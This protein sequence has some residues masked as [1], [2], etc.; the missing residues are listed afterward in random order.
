MT[1]KTI[2]EELVEGIINDLEMDLS[3]PYYKDLIGFDNKYVV[4]VNLGL[5]YEKTDNGLKL[6]KATP[7]EIGYCFVRLS[8]SKEESR[9]YPVHQVVMS[10]LLEMKIGEWKRFGFNEVNHKKV[11]K[12]YRSLNAWWNLELDTR[13]GNMSKARK[14]STRRKLT[15]D[16]VTQLREEFKTVTKNKMQWYF[17][18]AEELGCSY[19]TVQYNV[20][21]FYNKGI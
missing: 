1:N 6:K 7:N 10:A 5:I 20:L 2:F 3:Q 9:S 13:K 12:E 17:Q 16:E 21:G 19:T 15:V 8:G 14:A 4:D 11:G 18:K